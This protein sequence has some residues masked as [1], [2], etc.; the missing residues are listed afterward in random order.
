MRFSAT[1]SPVRRDL[2]T[3]TRPKAP[4]PNSSSQLTSYAS[5]SD[6]DRT[7][8][9]D[10]IRIVRERWMFSRRCCVASLLLVVVVVLVVTVV[11]LILLLRLSTDVG[12]DGV[13]ASSHRQLHNDDFEDNDDVTERGRIVVVDV[14]LTV[15]VVVGHARIICGG[16]SN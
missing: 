4:T 13:D 10:S 15:V 3:Y 5:A 7:A 16:S 9:V 2:A 14:V 8:F 12:V 11:E 1:I 6:R